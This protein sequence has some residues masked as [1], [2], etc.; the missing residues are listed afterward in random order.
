MTLKLHETG[1]LCTV[2]S[3][4][5]HTPAQHTPTRTHTLT[6]T[7]MYSTDDQVHDPNAARPANYV[8]LLSAL[9]RAHN[10]SLT[11]YL[12]H[13]H[14]HIN[15]RAPFFV[16]LYIYLCLIYD[17]FFGALLR[18]DDDSTRPTR[19][20]KE[21]ISYLQRL[22]GL[23]FQE[24]RLQNLEALT[25][26]PFFARDLLGIM[27]RGVVF[28]LVCCWG[29]F[30]HVCFC[31]CVVCACGFVHVCFVH[32]CLCSVVCAFVF[33]H[34]GLCMCILFMCMCFTAFPLLCLS[35][36]T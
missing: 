34:V 12:Q 33:V 28:N 26:F 8:Y 30:V 32:L 29:F 18:T 14:W 21:Y 1:E 4:L 13:S 5:I 15:A 16:V 35:L 27:D 31:T 9:A 20:T 19:F 10:M 36:A 6:L 11:H 3:Q 23:L 17:G 25:T 22:I 2:I 7:R 24:K